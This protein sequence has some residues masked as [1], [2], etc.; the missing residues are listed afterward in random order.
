MRRPSTLLTVTFSAFCFASAASGDAAVPVLQTLWKNGDDGVAVYRI[1]A[2]CTAPNGDL[3][4][5]CDARFQHGGDVD[6]YQRI[7]TACRRSTDGGR[8]WSPSKLT[9]DWPWKPSDEWSASDPSLVVDCGTGK[10]F[11]FVNVWHW[12][13]IPN[14]D[15]KLGVYRFFVQ[16]S[17]DNGVTWSKPRA[18]SKDIAFPDWPFGRPRGENGFIFITSGSGIQLK[19]G[20]LLHTIVHVGD[21]VALFGSTDH[22]RTWRPF[23]N[24]AKPG[25]TGD[26][27]KVVELRDGSLMINSR[28]ARGGR[29]VMIS[30]DRGETWQAFWDAS[31]PDPVCNGQLS[32]VGDSLVMVNCN[33]SSS[34]ENLWIRRSDDDGKTWNEG[35]CIFP[36]SAAYADFATNRKGNIG[37]LFERDNYSK[38]DFAIVSRRS[39]FAKP[40]PAELPDALKGRDSEIWL[41]A[42]QSNMQKGWDEFRATPEEEARVQKE[43]AQL[44]QAEV[45]LWDVND[46]AWTRLTPENAGRRSAYGV[47]FAI[48]RALAVKKPVA[49]LFV[50]AGGAPTESFL[51]RETMCKRDAHGRFVYPK[52]AA[53]ANNPM[54]MDLNDDFP[55]LW[56]K[57]EYRRRLGKASDARWWE[58]SKL[59]HS[60]IELVKDIPFT[61]ILWYQG[62]S[63]ASTCV[64]PDRPLDDDYMLET[65]LAI[66][67][68]LRGER[69]IPFLMMGLPKMNRPWEPYRNAQLKA[70]EA[71]NALYV[72]SLSANLGTPNDVHP[73]DKIPFAALAIRTLTPPLAARSVHM[74]H[75]TA[76]AEWIY[77]EA[78]VGESHPGSYFMIA[79]FSCGYSGVQELYDGSKVFIFS[80]WDPG[81]PFDFKIKEHERDVKLRTKVLYSGEGV[82]VSRFGGEGTGGKSMLPFD[83]KI[84]ETLRC[85]VRARRDGD[86]RAA[87]TGYVW[88]N[89]GWFKVATFST[90]QTKEPVVKDVYSF[91]EDFRRTREST[92]QVRTADFFNFFAKVNGAWQPIPKGRFTAD[93]NT[94]RT[95]D[96]QVIP[97][98]FRLMTGGKTKNTHIKLWAWAD[99]HVGA[100]PKECAALDALKD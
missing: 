34:R 45:W 99:T 46:R 14:H 6:F 12:D 68:Q 76:P 90:L 3:V 88:R 54:P 69:N 77:G 24:P 89:G 81:D 59:Y 87:F 79:G 2:I 96:A 53:I 33:H 82:N 4:A 39:V 63:N 15:R 8:T 100:Q 97:N 67:D 94:I 26:E 92:Q 85:A 74:W 56:C 65:N 32:R 58:V 57:R 66:I 28:W 10:I 22:G 30:R 49:M 31:L 35:F 86:H 5:V 25:K 18:I 52:L 42:G 19:D 93:N 9:W 23:G 71:K 44:N 70:C 38:I 91:V 43:L 83:W 73:R 29:E 62:E 72:D 21:G 7:A 84:G 98:G 80:V 47:S 55:C 48:R 40:K 27:C 13:D 1:P 78:K 17:A 51:S 36:G 20:T 95:I 37:I 61:G 64:S 11:L 75:P 16:E 60:G 50:A 41:C